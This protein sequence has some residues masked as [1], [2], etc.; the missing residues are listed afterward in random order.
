MQLWGTPQEI[1][2]DV[3]KNLGRARF[4]PSFHLFLNFR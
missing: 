1:W 2:Y 4:I 3:D